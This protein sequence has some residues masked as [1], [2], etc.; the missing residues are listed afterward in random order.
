MLMHSNKMRS[1]FS[2]HCIDKRTLF[3]TVTLGLKVQHRKCPFPTD[4]PQSPSRTSRDKVQQQFINPNINSCIFLT[5]RAREN[6][7][8]KLVK[9]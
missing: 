3:L 8:L 7:N 4:E 6:R 9:I 1:T 5:A 2:Y